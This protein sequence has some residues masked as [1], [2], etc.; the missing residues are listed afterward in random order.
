MTWVQIPLAEVA[1]FFFCRLRLFRHSLLSMRSF[2]SARP[3]IVN[4]GQLVCLHIHLHIPLTS[5]F[6]STETRLFLFKAGCHTPLTSVAGK[7]VSLGRPLFH[8]HVLYNNRGIVTMTQHELHTPQT[9][10]LVSCLSHNDAAMNVRQMRW[11]YHDPTAPIQQRRGNS[12]AVSS[13]TVCQHRSGQVM[14]RSAARG[15]M[16]MT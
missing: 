6:A 12:Q 9:W 7:R 11:Q 1:I 3:G 8:R 10:Y 2:A 13:E 4:L 14:R 16:S 5:H 15:P